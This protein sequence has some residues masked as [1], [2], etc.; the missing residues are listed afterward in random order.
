MCLSAIKESY[1][2]PS[3]LITDGWK[4]F[5]GTDLRPLFQSRVLGGSAE[6]PLDKWLRA[7]GVRDIPADDGNF[8]R[9]G[10]HAYSNEDQL[11]GKSWFR[12]VF[13]RQITCLGRQDGKDC[14]VA[15]E[16]YVPSDP[17]GW[18]PKEG[19]VATK[20]KKMMTKG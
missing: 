8:Y 13:L 18:P 15:Q 16:M 10:F 5:N 6:V 7:E 1:D 3:P 4:V 19:G 20:L 9:P 12:R 11:N 14:V 2:Q 17:N